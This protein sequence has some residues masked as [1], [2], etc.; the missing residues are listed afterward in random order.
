MSASLTR[1][2]VALFAA[3]LVMTIVLAH[4]ALG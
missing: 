2:L 1:W 4:A 3:G